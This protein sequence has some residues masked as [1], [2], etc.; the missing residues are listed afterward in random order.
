[1]CVRVCAD[2]TWKGNSKYVDLEVAFKP[3]GERKT[4]TK[5]ISS[6]LLEFSFITAWCI[7]L[8]LIVFQAIVTLDYEEKICGIFI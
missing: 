3:N 5:N 1:M 8:R 7:C 6:G 2:T 4:N